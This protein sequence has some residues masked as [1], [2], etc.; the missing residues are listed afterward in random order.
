[1]NKKYFTPAFRLIASLGLLVLVVVIFYFVVN[2]PLK[3]PVEK[4]LAVGAT[5]LT[6]YLPGKKITNTCANSE[7]G[8]LIPDG[9]LPLVWRQEAETTT[10]NYQ[11]GTWQIKDNALFIAGSTMDDGAHTL[12]WATSPNGTKYLVEYTDSCGLEVGNVFEPEL[13]QERQ[14]M[15]NQFLKDFPNLGSDFR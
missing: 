12:S 9:S 15:E 6:K 10:K 4:N 11:T 7:W 8:V 3:T 13:L 2:R 14:D 1:M 5:E